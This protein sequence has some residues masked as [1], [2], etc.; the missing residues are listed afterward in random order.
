MFDLGLELIIVDLQL[1]VRNFS[2]SPQNHLSPRATLVK[3]GSH[4]VDPFANCDHNA[5]DSLTASSMASNEPLPSISASSNIS[6]SMGTTAPDLSQDS[7]KCIK[8]IVF[9]FVCLK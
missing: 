6:R 5:I 4:H 8:C 2:H 1:C 3:K 7:H 9:C